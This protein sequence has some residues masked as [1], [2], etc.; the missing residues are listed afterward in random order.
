MNTSYT[1]NTHPTFKQTSH[2]TKQA[3]CLKRSLQLN[4][5]YCYFQTTMSS[6]LS[7]LLLIN[8]NLICPD[9]RINLSKK[10]FQYCSQF[11]TT[12]LFANITDLIQDRF[13]D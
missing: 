12:V 5:F 8:G 9:N 2:Q 13:Y 1:A 10:D 4:P 11:I 6:Y 3:I 7:D